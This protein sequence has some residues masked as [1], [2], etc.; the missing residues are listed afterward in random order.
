MRR[1]KPNYSKCKICA[2]FDAEKSNDNWILCSGK[3]GVDFLLNR[4][5]T[6]CPAFIERKEDEGKR[7]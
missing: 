6:K 7:S 5:S 3:P 2:N 1:P 4:D